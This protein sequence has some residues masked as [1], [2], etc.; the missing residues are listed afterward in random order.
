[1]PTKTN[2]NDAAFLDR[3]NRRL[4]LTIIG[5]SVALALAIV[6]KTPTPLSDDS[7]QASTEKKVTLVKQD[8]AWTLDKASMATLK[9]MALHD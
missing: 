2:S 7:N 1:V 8:P 3:V 9:D 5:L 4:E 6:G